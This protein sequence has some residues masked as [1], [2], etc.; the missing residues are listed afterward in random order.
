[1]KLSS[2]AVT[3]A[4]VGLVAAQR[5][6]HGH[7]RHHKRDDTAFQYELDGVVIS[8]E[9]ACEGIKDGSLEW[10]DGV[11]P[12]GACAPTTTGS[13]S[14]SIKPA[15]FFQ[16]TTTTTTTTTKPPTTTTTTTTTTSKPPPPTTTSTTT[17]AAP[18][19]TAVSDVATGLT[20]PFPDG[21]LDCSTFPS[22]YGAVP[23][24]YLG[25]SGYT[26]IQSV[27]IVGELVTA[28]VNGI[29]G[30]TC[31]E[32]DMCSY[33]CPPGYQKSQWPSTQ[34]S[35]GQSVGGIT[36][37]GGKLY[38]TN[39]AYDTL[40]IPGVGDVTVTNTLGQQVA[41]CRTDYPGKLSFIPPP[42]AAHFELIVVICPLLY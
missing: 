26:G 14:S 24:D 21:E 19:A 31:R 1:M 30:A 33:A 16:S 28:I 38:K 22:A 3:L 5:H 13:T 23:L 32:G 11:P 29:E 40:C 12:P 4:T 37:K 42:L 39:P 2:V 7:K 6:G 15:E 9:Q 17:S 18:A 34:G 10:L 20:A 8:P 36:C 27:T 41:F 35:T 25:L